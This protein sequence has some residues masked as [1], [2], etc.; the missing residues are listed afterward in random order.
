MEWTPSIM[1]PQP[2]KL[3]APQNGMQP[4]LVGSIVILVGLAVGFVLG[5]V[6][7]WHQTHDSSANPNATD[8]TVAGVLT[9]FSC[10]LGFFATKGRKDL[11]IPGWYIFLG[12]IICSFIFAFGWAQIHRGLKLRAGSAAE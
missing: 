11:D 3:N 4:I 5:T 9:V 1:T 12:G 6:L 2:A 10:I 8:M 7:L